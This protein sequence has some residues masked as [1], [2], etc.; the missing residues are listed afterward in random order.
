MKMENINIV[1]GIGLVGVL[2]AGV[3]LLALATFIANKRVKHLYDANH[4]LV[5]N[6]NLALSFRRTG[7]LIGLAIPLAG[8]LSVDFL[9]IGTFLGSLRDA[10]IIIVLMFI[11]LALSDKFLLPNMDND[12][13]IQSKNMTVGII[14][15][16]LL[17]ATGLVLQGSFSGAGVWYSSIVFFVLGQIILIGTVKI[18][19]SRILKKSAS[20]DYNKPIAI[21]MASYLIGLGIIM[22][23]SLYGDFTSWGSDI[24]SFLIWAA[25]GIALLIVLTTSLI[26][27]VFLHTSS[28]KQEIEDENIAGMLYIGAIKISV[29]LLVANIILL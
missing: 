21:L 28:I 8:S 20:H 2:I 26:N 5:E 18:Y 14:D 4:E 13:E 19:A 16:G 25:V 11:S 27:K 29:S 6:D 3:A 9:T 22:R 12:K 15:F 23:T 10:T 7:L 24:C 1:G 17:I